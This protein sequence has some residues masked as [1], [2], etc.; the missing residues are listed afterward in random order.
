MSAHAW[1]G[2][3]SAVLEKIRDATS[4]HRLCQ[5]LLEVR[6]PTHSRYLFKHPQDDRRDL[7]LAVIAINLPP[8]K[9]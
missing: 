1:P 2:D 6:S 9:K 5:R 3:H 7:Y 8:R 4:S